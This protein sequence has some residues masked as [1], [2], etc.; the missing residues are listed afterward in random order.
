MLRMK[1]CLQGDFFPFFIIYFISEFLLHEFQQSKVCILVNK[2]FVNIWKEFLKKQSWSLMLWWGFIWLNLSVL[3][4]HRTFHLT[5]L[6]EKD[7]LFS[8]L[9]FF[10]LSDKFSTKT[11]LNIRL[12]MLSIKKGIW[13]FRHNSIVER[14]LGKI[15]NLYFIL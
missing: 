11:F 6:F 9:Y 10:N 2:T 12:S 3:F 15:E 13:L 14:F 8:K 5:I 4:I 1:S 7:A